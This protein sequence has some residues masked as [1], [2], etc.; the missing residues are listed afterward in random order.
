MSVE[1]KRQKTRKGFGY[2]KKFKRYQKDKTQHRSKTYVRHKTS[3]RGRR[4]LKMLSVSPDPPPRSS[5]G[6]VDDTLHDDSSPSL[7]SEK[8]GLAVVKQESAAQGSVR[9]S[10]MSKSYS[11]SFIFPL[12]CWAHG[13]TAPGEPFVIGDLIDLTVADASEEEAEQAA[14][15]EAAENLSDLLRT[16]NPFW[17]AD[18]SRATAAATNANEVQAG[19]GKRHTPAPLTD[20]S[21]VPAVLDGTTYKQV[22]APP[23]QP[24]K[25]GKP[26]KQGTKS[27][28][29]KGPYKGPH[30]SVISVA[31]ITKLLDNEL[32]ERTL[33]KTAVIDIRSWWPLKEIT[34]EH[35]DI[36]DAAKWLLTHAVLQWWRHL[37]DD[38]TK[39]YV[40]VPKYFKPPCYKLVNE[41]QVARCQKEAVF[42]RVQKAMSNRDDT[43][44]LDSEFKLSPSKAKSK[45][46]AQ[47]D[48]SIL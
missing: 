6:E 37:K 3:T 15:A 8:E 18:L 4:S 31:N 9:V 1:T 32:A 40:D 39:K 25:Q 2:Y 42:F 43:P 5:L 29:E 10:G 19:I 7:S 47:V 46:G 38:A 48:N 22:L 28:K 24:N 13:L 12:R 21:N 30:L 44:A 20:V 41:I 14:P 26:E 23:Q 16:R 34:A 36:T 27:V 35:A 11:C 45:I 17:Q 33:T